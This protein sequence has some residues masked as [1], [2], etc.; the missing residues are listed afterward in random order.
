MA[1]WLRLALPR[2][3]QHVTACR[4]AR[5]GIASASGKADR[6]GKRCGCAGGTRTLSRAT[7]ASS[8]LSVEREYRANGQALVSPILSSNGGLLHTRHG[9]GTARRTRPQFARRCD[10]GA[11]DL[12]LSITVNF[13]ESK[14]W[15]RRNT[16]E[17]QRPQSGCARSCSPVMR[18]AARIPLGARSSRA[19]TSANRP[20]VG[21][22]SRGPSR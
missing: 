20:A 13:I 8:R 11:C 17:P 6:S 19:W 12:F 3:L 22:T 15:R 10:E 4:N 1:R 5:H 7:S 2:V 9:L 16:G 14:S 18:P 21:A